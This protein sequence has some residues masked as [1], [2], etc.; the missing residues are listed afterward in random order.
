MQRV[1]LKGSEN[2]LGD[3]P[4]RNTADRDRVEDLPVLAGPVKRII[5]KMFELPISDDDERTQMARF[6]DQLESDEPD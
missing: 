5:K 4:S 3:A 6:L 2:I 1:W